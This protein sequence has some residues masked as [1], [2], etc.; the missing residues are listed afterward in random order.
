MVVSLEGVAVQFRSTRTVE[1]NSRMEF[2]THFDDG[3]VQDG[4]VVVTQGHIDFDFLLKEEVMKEGSS[5]VLV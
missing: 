2:H 4:S 3:K 1:L 5:I